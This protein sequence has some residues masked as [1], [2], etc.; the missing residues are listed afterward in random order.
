MVYIQEAHPIDAWQDEDNEKDH[1]ALASP[2]SLDE[3][4]HVATTCVVKLGLK[5]PAVVD[6]FANSTET[7]YTAWPDRLYVVDREG[8]IA[9]KSRPGPFGFH[10]IEVGKTLETLVGGLPTLR[11][12]AAA[13]QAS[14]H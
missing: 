9:Y 6:D 1:I 14:A 10:P 11:D 3:R 12:A 13:Q 7:S 8:R 2:T 4:C 5:L